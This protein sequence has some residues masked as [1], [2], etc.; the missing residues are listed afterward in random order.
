M[1]VQNKFTKTYIFDYLCPTNIDCT[2][3][4]IGLHQGIYKFQLYG[5]YGGVDQGKI[6]SFIDNK[7]NWISESL[8]EEYNGN[9]KCVNIGSRDGVGGEISGIIKLSHAITA[10]ATIGG[11]LSK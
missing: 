2:D 5:A 1:L 6:S 4:I 11:H 8:V 3:Y 7:G 9:T 10:Y